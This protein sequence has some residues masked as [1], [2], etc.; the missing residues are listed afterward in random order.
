MKPVGKVIELKGANNRATSSEKII[1]ACNN[2]QWLSNCISQ[3]ILDTNIALPLAPDGSFKNIIEENL[4]SHSKV[5]DQAA[6][7][8]KD[9]VEAMSNYLNNIDAM[10]K[11]DER[12]LRPGNEILLL[13][14][15]EYEND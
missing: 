10:T 4:K 2:I 6:D 5:L 8:L 7:I 15:D 13:G 9:V 14:M 11:M 12:I 1:L 3:L